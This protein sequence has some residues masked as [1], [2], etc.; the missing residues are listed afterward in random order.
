VESNQRPS[1]CSTF[2]PPEPIATGLNT[3]RSKIDRQFQS[4]PLPVSPATL[5]SPAGGQNGPVAKKAAVVYGEIGEL[6]LEQDLVRFARGDLYCRG[7]SRGRRKGRIHLD[8]ILHFAAR[9]HLVFGCDGRLCRASVARGD[10]ATVA[11]FGGLN[12]G[13]AVAA[14]A[15]RHSG[16]RHLAIKD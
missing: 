5:E 6:E 9:V 13:L 14:G 12:C 16:P 10:H 15:G 3:G 11:R 2:A 8:A 1:P 7:V 4:H